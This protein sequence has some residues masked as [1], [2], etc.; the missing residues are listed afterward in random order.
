[1]PVWREKHE[2]LGNAKERQ[3]H[4]AS[5]H[6]LYRLH[7]Q[8]DQSKSSRDLYKIQGR[9]PARIN[10]E[11]GARGI[12]D[13]YLISLYNDPSTI[14]ICAILFNDIMPGVVWIYKGLGRRSTAKGVATRGW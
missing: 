3:L 6:P 10:T 14:A 2:Y 13:G 5:P 1:M 8:R 7:S 11:D 4:V 9:E 12:E